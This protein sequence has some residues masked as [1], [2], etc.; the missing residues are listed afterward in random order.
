MKPEL[1]EKLSE[2]AA[3]HEVHIVDGGLHGFDRLDPNAQT[4]S[5]IE[6]SRDFL[7]EQLGR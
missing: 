3:R 7:R 6:R 2:V 5:L 4:R 1:A